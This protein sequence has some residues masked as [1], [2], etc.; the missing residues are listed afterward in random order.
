MP[1]TDSNGSSAPTKSL[2][3]ES[4]KLMSAQGLVAKVH[5]AKAT[6]KS[7][8]QLQPSEKVVFLKN[9]H[10]LLVTAKAEIARLNA[11]NESLQQQ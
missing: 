10:S 5:E 2:E 7:D 3:D 11:R 1:K 4:L 8:A 9:F 6:V